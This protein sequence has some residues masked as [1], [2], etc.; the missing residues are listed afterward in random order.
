M[1]PQRFQAMTPAERER[2]L[3]RILD[4]MIVVRLQFGFNQLD[5]A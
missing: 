1:N 5:T 4:R 3:S 2:A